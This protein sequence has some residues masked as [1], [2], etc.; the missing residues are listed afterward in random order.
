MNIYLL[1]EFRKWAI[2]DF[3]NFIKLTTGKANKRLIVE[4]SDIIANIL[5]F[6]I[7]ASLIFLYAR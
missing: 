6:N 4:F 7:I 2:T 1:M 3:F 5:L